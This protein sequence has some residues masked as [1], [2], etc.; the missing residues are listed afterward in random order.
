MTDS[1]YEVDSDSSL[2]DH[3]VY[4]S[5]WTWQVTEQDEAEI[6]EEEEWAKAKMIEVVNTLGLPDDLGA[7]KCVKKVK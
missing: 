4:T 5:K 1:E 6:W 2:S 3:E 7:I